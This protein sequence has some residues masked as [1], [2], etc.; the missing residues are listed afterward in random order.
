MTVRPAG[1][2]PVVPADRETSLRRTALQLEGMF[3]TQ[4][5]QAMRAT[6]PDDGL[7]GGGPGEA[8]FT[9]MLDEHVASQTPEHWRGHG[10][11]EALVRQ[12]RGMGSAPDVAPAAPERTP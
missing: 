8:M 6:V 2:T 3:V 1:A 9:G 12:L 11:A 4:L 5:Y 10:L 7:T